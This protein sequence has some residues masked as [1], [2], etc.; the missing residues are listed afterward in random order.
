MSELLYSGHWTLLDG[1][2]MK[3]QERTLQW[4]NSCWPASASGLYIYA[5]WADGRRS[6]TR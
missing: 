3:F 5:I 2:R 1:T 6:E 4:V